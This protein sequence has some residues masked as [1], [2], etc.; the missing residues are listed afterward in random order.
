[1]ASSPICL[2]SSNKEGEMDKKK[3]E[4]FYYLIET[5]E[6]IG[7]KLSEIIV[8]EDPDFIL[9]IGKKT[10]G[11]EVTGYHIDAGQKKGSEARTAEES[12]SYIVEMV[13][14][15]LKKNSN[16]ESIWAHLA[17]NYPYYPQKVDLEKFSDD[18]IKFTTESIRKNKNLKEMNLKPTDDYPLLKKCLKSV[19]LWREPFPFIHFFMHD[20]SG[21]IGLS[22]ENL[23]NV[24]QP[25]IEKITKY[26]KSGNF[27]ELWLI[28]GSGR[29]HSQVIPPLCFVE[30]EL[31]EFKKLDNV[32]ENSG[33]SKIYL[34]FRS[35]NE[36]VFEW[37]GWNKIE[38]KHIIQGGRDY[39][40]RKS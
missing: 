31:K 28:V 30:S 37:P 14:E 7:L 1:L 19:T 3:I 34:C 35:N 40:Q 33:F 8:R 36:A 39:E 29:F 22:E 18:L 20:Y 27:D 9:K 2:E 12:Y 4:E 15:K 17:F 21:N 16:L 23:I 13:N 25:K 32:L 24:I 5:I 38:P 6:T 11:A 26:K 10:I